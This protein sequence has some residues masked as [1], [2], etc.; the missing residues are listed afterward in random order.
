MK[1]ENNPQQEHDQKYSCFSTLYIIALKD[2]RLERGIHQ[3]AISS[4]IGKAPS[5]WAK[6]ES[7][8]AGLNLNAMFAASNA[9]GI[10]PSQLTLIV[11]RLIGELG[12]AGWYFSPSD[13]TASEDPL[14]QKVIE[15]YN[16][17]KYK[18][19][20]QDLTSHVSMLTLAGPYNPFALPL[21]VRYCCDMSMDTHPEDQHHPLTMSL[22]NN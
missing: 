19:S 9:L 11:E 6:I 17:D 3:A 13:I 8:Q 7:G 10:W 12:R 20:R 5:A 1:D 14:L 21:V 22:S 2:I 16:S 15:F 18:T 4:A